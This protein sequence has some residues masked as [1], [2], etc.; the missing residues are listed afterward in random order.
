MHKMLEHDARAIKVVARRQAC[1]E[2]QHGC[3]ALGKSDPIEGSPEVPMAAQR[4]DAD[5]GIS[6]MDENLFVLLIPG[7]ERAPAE[8]SRAG[9]P[10]NRVLA[11][12]PD[13]IMTLH[14]ARAQAMPMRR[15][16][17]RALG[18]LIAGEEAHADFAGRDVALRIMHPF[19]YIAR[20][21]RVEDLVAA[22]SRT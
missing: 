18:V 16:L 8:T 11:G 20:L 3:R 15:P 10:G 4:V 5:A 17:P 21:G 19:P 1:F 2:N 13:G 14:A 22:K 9:R 12:Y 7:I 6:G